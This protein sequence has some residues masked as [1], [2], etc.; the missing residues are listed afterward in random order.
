MG[1]G[2][3]SSMNSKGP[4]WSMSHEKSSND[5]LE[6]AQSSPGRNCATLVKETLSLETEAFAAMPAPVGFRH[7]LR[8]HVE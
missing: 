4:T 8:R 1:N 3:T 7:Y 6:W 5:A 2:P